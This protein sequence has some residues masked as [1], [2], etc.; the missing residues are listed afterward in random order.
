MPM[1]LY[2]ELLGRRGYAPLPPVAGA[3]RVHRIVDR[4]MGDLGARGLLQAELGDGAAPVGILGCDGCERCVEVCPTAAIRVL[5]SVESP[6]LA[7]DESR[8][9]GFSCRLCE[10]A[11]PEKV[12]LLTD[13]FGIGAPAPAR[14][15]AP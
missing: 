8:C 6:M 12:L 10:H 11:C 7:L 15:I 9:L 4:D 13:F 3:P 1:A 14:A 5:G 2:R